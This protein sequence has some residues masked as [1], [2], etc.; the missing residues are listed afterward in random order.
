[1]SLSVQRSPHFNQDFSLQ[2]E[3]YARH[4]SEQVA[5]DY[6]AA[7][8]QTIHLLKQQP[9]LGRLRRFRHPE[10]EAIRSFRVSPPFDRNILFYRFEEKFL[11]AERVLYGT[12]DLPRRL[13]EPPAA[14]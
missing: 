12:R 5:H 1:M 4:G 6:H 8:E 10:L 2:A 9:E 7:V 11:Y 13:L 3:W 14:D